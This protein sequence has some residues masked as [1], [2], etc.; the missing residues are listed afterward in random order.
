MAN[1][2]IIYWFRNDLRIHDNPVFFKALESE[3]PII[4]VFIIDDIWFDA[5]HPELGFP[6]TGSKRKIFLAE[7]LK[8]LKLTL[9]KH[10]NTL[11]IFKGNT[12]EIL[13]ELSKEIKCTKI[14]AQKEFAWEEIEIEKAVMKQL[15]LELH[16]GSMLYQPDQVDFPVEKSPFYYTRFK[17]KVLNQPYSP[18]PKKQQLTENINWSENEISLKNTKNFNPEDWINDT[19]YSKFKGGESRALKRMNEYLNSEGV[20][21]YKKT[22]NLFEGENFSSQL[23]PWLANGA[24]SPRILYEKLKQRM[25]Q[26]PEESESINTIIEQLIWR[27]N[28]RFLFL[29]YGR[30]FF[31]TKGLRKTPH[32][33]YNDFE[34]F[35]MWRKGQTG[36]P[37]IDALM[38]ELEATGFM[39]NRGRMLVSYYLAKELKVNWQWGAAW[40]ESVLI[41]YDV[42]NNYGNWAYQSGRGTDSRVNR[43]F[44]LETQTKKF[45]PERTFIKKWS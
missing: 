24:L 4:P 31:L 41:D 33:M 14:I 6:R 35:E 18:Q 3:A 42:Y 44:N 9:Q 22:R 7:T 20:G 5:D 11:F 1:P 13:N 19:E 30:N 2:A 8:D 37:I 40:F 38:H 12:F 26:N 25:S 23:G 36:Q 15:P 17:N 29:R 10:G 39:S 28:F 16:Y 34:A 32:G 45:D 27:D 21:Q 43:K